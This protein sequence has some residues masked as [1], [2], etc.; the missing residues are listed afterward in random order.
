ML[1]APPASAHPIPL[2]CQ[3]LQ[4]P[5]FPAR[6]K[7][8]LDS[9][10]RNAGRA[11]AALQSS[12]MGGDGSSHILVPPTLLGLC[13]FAR[14]CPSAFCR[15]EPR[16]VASQPRCGRVLGPARVS[17]CCGVF[18]NGAPSQLGLDSPKKK[19]SGKAEAPEPRSSPARADLDE[20]D[21]H[22]EAHGRMPS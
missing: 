16:P 12:A 1:P 20:Q 15:A 21:G 3:A 7:L 9:F 19:A 22:A 10:Q 6:L 5:I 8:S 4:Y 18:T 14:I 17:L 2:P 11:L 13:A